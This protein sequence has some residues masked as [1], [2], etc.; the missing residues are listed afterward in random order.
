[1]FK[2]AQFE[3]GYKDLFHKAYR[4][5]RSTRLGCQ[6]LLPSFERTIVSNDSALTLADRA[7]QAR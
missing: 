7:T 4:A 6:K 3:L 5:R 1:M 2:W